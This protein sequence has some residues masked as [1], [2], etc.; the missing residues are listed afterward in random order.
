MEGNVGPTRS[1]LPS[2]SSHP[3]NS[4]KF[5]QSPEGLTTE[6]TAVVAKAAP[7]TAGGSQSTKNVEVTF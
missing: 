1:K 5:S 2:S 7:E 3:V 6:K 4:S